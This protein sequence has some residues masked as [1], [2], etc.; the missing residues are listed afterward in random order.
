LQATV[1]ELIAVPE[2]DRLMVQ[3]NKTI[4]IALALVQDSE[5]HQHL[6]YAVS[7]NYTN[8]RIEAAAEN[9]GLT[10]WTTTPKSGVPGPT[11]APADAEQL[12]QETVN[13]NDEYVMLGVPAASRPYC[14]DC[15]A[16]IQHP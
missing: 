13:T 7:G 11:G 5:G 4:A 15:A 14:G 10:R 16:A 9:L 1:E 12:L 6:V 2:T 3:R 8:P